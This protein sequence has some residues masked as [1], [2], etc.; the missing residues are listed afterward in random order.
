[1]DFNF[2]H[3]ASFNFARFEIEETFGL[4]WVKL[5]NGR[6]YL[7]IFISGILKVLVSSM[8]F[9]FAHFVYKESCGQILVKITEWSVRLG[10][11]YFGARFTNYGVP[12]CLFWI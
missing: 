11:C 12:F 9:I 4:I 10:N 3:F 5:Q 7:K 8:G 1:M 6:F 2:A